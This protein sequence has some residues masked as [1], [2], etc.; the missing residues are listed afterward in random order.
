MNK[1]NFMLLSMAAFLSTNLTFT[2]EK[3]TKNK[4][5]TVYI[6]KFD[7]TNLVDCKREQDA[8]LLAHRIAQAKRTTKRS[9]NTSPLAIKETVLF[10]AIDDERR[11]PNFCSQSTTFNSPIKTSQEN[12]PKV[13]LSY[14]PEVESPI[15]FI[16]RASS[17][18]SIFY[19]PPKFKL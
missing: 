7:P 5:Q 12:R 4:S 17:R 8:A 1:I 18:D 3:N 16:C 19:C 13:N 14:R 2:S 9:N 11:S 15:A 6:K 10:L